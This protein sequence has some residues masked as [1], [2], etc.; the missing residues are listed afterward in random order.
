[1]MEVAHK[2]LSIP[3]TPYIN[4]QKFWRTNWRTL[5]LGQNMNTKL[6]HMTREELA[7]LD[8]ALS[9]PTF[10]ASY[11]DLHGPQTRTFYCSS[12]SATQDSAY[13]QDGEWSGA[14]FDMIEV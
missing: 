12:F 8:D 5:R 2:F 13:S 3:I 11:L 7:A 1:M 10:S 14:A 4:R 6:V 9:A